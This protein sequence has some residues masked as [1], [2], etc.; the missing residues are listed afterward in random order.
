MI[1]EFVNAYM[2]NKDAFRLA[3]SQHHPENYLTLVKL[4]IEAINP[5]DEYGAPAPNKIHVIDDGRYSGT[6]LFII[7]EGGY[8]PS[9]YW[10]TTASYG[11]CSGCDTLKKIR[12]SSSEKP[13]PEQVEQYLTL[14]LHLV[15]KLKQITE[16]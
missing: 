4:L 15:Q 13:T 3:L 14:M 5:E 16:G 8:Q 9:T 2:K 11:S 1:Q 12:R 6:L 7:P 10:M